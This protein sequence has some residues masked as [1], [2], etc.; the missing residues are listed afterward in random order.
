[1]DIDTII[2]GSIFGEL[3]NH[4][5]NYPPF[6]RPLLGMIIGAFLMK[7]LNYIMSR[8]EDKAEKVR[9][10]W[11]NFWLKFGRHR[12][13]SLV[14]MY[15]DTKAEKEAFTGNRCSPGFPELASF[16]MQQT[17]KA[18]E[19]YRL[20]F[21]DDTYIAKNLKNH[22]LYPNCD[23]FVDMETT[24]EVVDGVSLL[25]SKLIVRSRSHQ[26]SYLHQVVKKIIEDVN[27]DAHDGSIWGFMMRKNEDCHTFQRM[28]LN[29]N[30]NWNHLILNSRQRTILYTYLSRFQDKSW[31]LNMGVPYKATFLL[32][33][34][35]GTGKTT[36]IKIL[37]EQYRRHVVLFSL[38]SLKNGEFQ[39]L[40]YDY[41]FKD[42]MEKFIY[43]FEDIDADTKAVWS[44]D[45][46]QSLKT[47][48]LE[49]KEDMEKSFV[50]STEVKSVEQNSSTELTLA[51]ILQMLDG[52]IE[53]TGLMVVATTNHYE[54]LDPAF[55]RR[56]HCRL[57]LS[58][59]CHE[60]ADM[61]AQRFFGHTFTS[62]EWEKVGEYVT[63]KTPN[64]I[65]EMATSSSNWDFFL[66][67]LQS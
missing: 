30:K 31:Y 53:N 67:E 29:T 16:V 60:T 33:G 18:G 43:V 7:L 24:K 40:F 44:R 57:E 50:K 62:D 13:N 45:F 54:R 52:V 5:N 39:E 15:E 9:D 51:T 55:I 66:Q 12:E 59:C 22:R 56:F 23:I 17:E 8:A 10:N 47:K 27:L 6:V 21:R 26:V 49:D 63:K 34:P 41:R 46:Q 58:Y 37:A 48:S 19:C 32:Y 36:I 3:N 1:M 42:N 64:N 35:P 14:F 2:R 4:L 61:I 28:K 25:R 65:I 11:E 38:K 20:S